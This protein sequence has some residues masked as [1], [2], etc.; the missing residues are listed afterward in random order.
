[1]KWQRIAGRVLTAA[2]AVVLAVFEVT[3]NTP[4][5][6]GPGLVTATLIINIF[7]GSW[8]PPA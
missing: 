1:M 4:G 7:L 3:G 5:W 6:W 8:K 2:V